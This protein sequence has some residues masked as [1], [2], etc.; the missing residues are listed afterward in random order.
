MNDVTR[1]KSALAIG[2]GAM[3]VLFAPIAIGGYF[4]SR[5]VADRLSSAILTGAL[6]F[7]G[8][9]VAQWTA[10]YV[11]RTHN[12]SLKSRELKTR[13]YVANWDNLFPVDQ[14]LPR[15]PK[16]ISPELFLVASED[17]LKAIAALNESSPAADPPPDA[18]LNLMLT[19][20]KDLG[21]S[22]DELIA[23][24]VAAL[25]ALPRLTP[26]SADQEKTQRGRV[27]APRSTAGR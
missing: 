7:L 15:V 17:V 16:S 21:Q 9:Q 22:S 1:P 14:T 26:P 11:E 24:D 20:R 12:A 18:A 19:I 4:I 27:P 5:F 10:G 8:S 23:T 3:I 13:A 25:F 2:C 6:V